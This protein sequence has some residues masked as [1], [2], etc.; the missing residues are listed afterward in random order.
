[1]IVLVTVSSAILAFCLSAASMEITARDRIR[2]SVRMR[3]LW[4]KQTFQTPI[5]RVKQKR[6]GRIVA[7]RAFAE[8]LLS[9][10]IRMRPEEF[11]VFWL[12]A[13]LLPA[14]VL[15]ALRVHPATLITVGLIGAIAPI[16]VIS[17]RRKKQLILFEEQLGDALLLMGNCLR[18]GLTFQQAMA[19][20]AREMPDPIARQFA[21]T[22]REIQLGNSVDDALSAMIQRVRSTDLMLTV[23]AVQI[24][25]QVGGNLLEILENI[26]GTIKERIRLK[27]DIRVMTAT[28]RTSGMIVGMIPLAI[29]GLLTLINPEYM[30][31]FLETKIGMILL[32]VAAGLEMVGFL[33]IKKIITI[34]Y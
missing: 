22:V 17:I 15:L 13:A 6:T 25:R 19:N 11:L 20:I 2:M 8:Q 32:F 14:L 7:S 16:A 31:V 29:A 9:A 21:R 18:S 26:S 28:G 23:S 3:A 1:M 34:Q 12:M 10:G 24:Q 30:S 4:G 33:V 5:H 27:N